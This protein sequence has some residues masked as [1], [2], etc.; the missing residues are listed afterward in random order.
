RIAR[1]PSEPSLG[2]PAGA[3]SLGLGSSGSLMAAHA[4][5]A[6]MTQAPV[7]VEVTRGST[8]ESV[9]R[10]HVAVVDGAGGLVAHAG[11]PSLLTFLR[12]AAKPFQAVP[13]VA[14]GA[15]DAFGLTEEELALCCGSHAGEPMHVAL[16]ESMLRK[17][18][19]SADLLQCGTHPPFNKPGRAALAGAK[20]TP[21]HHNCSGKHAG[22]MLTQKHL[23]ADPA[24][25][26]E[27]DALV[28]RRI[29]DAI[30]ACAGVPASDVRVGTDGC[31]VPNF[32]LPLAAGARLFARLAM[33]QGVAPE[34]ATALARL[35]RAMTR[36]PH[37]V[38]GSAERFDTDLMGASEDRLVS[39]AGAEGV[40]GVGDLASGMG[41]LLKVEDGA[42]RAVGP[43]TA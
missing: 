33:P 27:P 40:Q 5:C 15:A 11:D 42:S 37:L 29:L 32:A 24:R 12:S 18:G 41:L 30:A 36:H 16:A 8:V 38:G 2:G 28:Q 20:P 25:Y 4:C 31:S 10:V 21:L 9:H 22:M 34:I 19:L 26:F 39:K 3:S 1:R 14:S 13:L 7:G 23:G 43:A 35:Q 17:G 6:P